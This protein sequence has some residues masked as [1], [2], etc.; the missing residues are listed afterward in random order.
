[1]DDNAFTPPGEAPALRD[2]DWRRYA[3]QEAWVDLPAQRRRARRRQRF[4]A[5][6]AVLAVAVG[7]GALVY[8]WGIPAYRGYLADRNEGPK[9][10]PDRGRVD[11]AKPF[12]H[13]AAQNWSEGIDGLTTPPASQVGTFS[14]RETADA[15]EA[16][17]RTITA[18]FLDRE[19]IADHKPDHFVASIAPDAA[20]WEI[21]PEGLRKGS[22]V[23]SVADGFR[24]LPVS[25]RMTG[26]LTTRPGDPGKLTVHAS[27]VVAYAFDPG[28]RKI[29]GPSDIEPFLRQE[30][31]YV[32]VSA[33]APGYEKTSIGVWPGRA[34]GV[35]YAA[36]CKA[37]RKNQLAPMLYTEETTAPTESG[38]VVTDPG[39]FDPSKPLPQANECP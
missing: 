16:V 8:Y 28:D 33:A 17:K 39:I 35:F 6:A 23:I 32:V 31:D 19:V 12:E 13:T 27:F 2:P 1:M 29:D 20:R 5:L 30:I 10:L 7:G 18:S 34:E 38:P 37:I 9:G 3:Q 22:S 25:P 36:A 14:P 15:M 11:L 24:L 26:S 21:T 4:V